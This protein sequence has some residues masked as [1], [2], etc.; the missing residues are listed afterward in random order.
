MLNS[1]SCSVHLA[2][3]TTRLQPSGASSL[4]LYTKHCLLTKSCTYRA[5]SAKGRCGFPMGFPSPLGDVFSNFTEEPC[6]LTWWLHLFCFC[7]SWGLPCQTLATSP[8][9]PCFYRWWRHETLA[10]RIGFLQKKKYS[11]IFKKGLSDVISFFPS[12]PLPFLADR[13]SE[14]LF[15]CSHRSQDC[16]ELLK[17]CALL[18]YDHFSSCLLDLVFPVNLLI[19]ATLSQ[20]INM[21]IA[22]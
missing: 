4:C 14:V 5:L 21:Y 18:R 9:W 12:F 10:H 20:L 11:L 19:K 8:R 6:G 13:E 17:M 7:I 22:S 3:G 2:M 16:Q 1:S 15:E